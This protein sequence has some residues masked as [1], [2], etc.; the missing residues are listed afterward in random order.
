MASESGEASTVMTSSM[1]Q[2]FFEMKKM[3]E[4]I[5]HD[6]CEKSDKVQT[7]EQEN[8]HLQKENEE[9]KRLL[10][11]AN[12]EKQRLEVLLQEF[13]E[14]RNKRSP[15]VFES[16]HICGFCPHFED[17]SSSYS[18]LTPPDSTGVSSVTKPLANFA[19]GHDWVNSPGAVECA[20]CR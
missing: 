14:E 1:V 3:I 9:L 7:L 10:E 12:V 15:L 19:C 11:E 8:H 16:G 18:P 20:Y 17:T 6:H 5:F 4:T 13:T 2:E